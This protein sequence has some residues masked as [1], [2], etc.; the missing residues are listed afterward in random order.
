M[1]ILQIFFVSWEL[2]LGDKAI[3]LAASDPVKW[4]GTNLV[5]STGPDENLSKTSEKSKQKTG[6]KKT[7]D[8]SK[9]LNNV[10]LDL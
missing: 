2:F 4:P 10:G 9:S 1:L 5:F 6:E 7:P 8:I 3:P